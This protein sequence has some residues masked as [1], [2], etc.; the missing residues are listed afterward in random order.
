MRFALRKLNGYGVIARYKEYLI[1]I[2]LSWIIIFVVSLI[3]KL[4]N[5]SILIKVCLSG[6]SIEI[7]ISLIIITFY[8]DKKIIDFIKG[9]I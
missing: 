6:V 3:F 1:S 8:E 7:I 9:G 5:I 4:T 2:I